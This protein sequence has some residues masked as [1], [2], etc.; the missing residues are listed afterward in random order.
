MVLELRDIVKTFP[1]VCALDGARFDLRPGEVHALI[2]ENG[3]GKSTLMNIIAGVLRP[4]AGQILLDGRPVAFRNPHHASQHGIA[5][6]FQE[7]SLVP[8]MCIAENM[9][10][11]RQPVGALNLIKWND[12]Y[13]RAAQYLRLFDMTVNPATPVRHLSVAQR[14][15]VEILKALS[16]EPRVVIL[17]EPTSSLT[18]IE[19]NLLFDNIR[20][21]KAQ[22]VAFIYISHHLSEIFQIADRVTVMR[23]GKYVQT[24]NV[25]EA[26]EDLL[27]RRMVGREL[28]NVY[29][30]RAAPVGD[31]YFRIEQASR[32]PD[33][34]DIS[35]HL[36]RGEILGLAGLVGA[37]R[38]Q[39][40]RALA[41]LE[42]LRHGQIL[43]D[44]SPL[45]IRSPQ[46]AIR[47]GIGYLTEDR[48]DQGLFLRMPIRDNCI[49]PSLAR[50]ANA[51]GAVDESRVDR[52]AESSRARFNIITPSTRQ[53]VGHL[54]GGN[55]QKVLL[56]MW[57]GIQPKV[58]IIDEPTRGVDV[59][60]RSDIYALLRDLAATGVGILM[61]S[62][63]LQEILGL[64][65]RILVM[66]SGRLAAEFSR[67]H[68]TE[69]LIIAAA[70]GARL[71]SH[72]Q[73]TH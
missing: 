40:A 61:V 11:H 64:S 10:A 58:L 71:E 52:F 37:G 3:A 29:G 16:Q 41:G 32:S 68:A 7:L 27:I 63:D 55:Q 51:L 47:H 26:T 24:L 67:E 18:A 1:G 46:Q 59:G 19:T 2:G 72:V 30:Q 33:F 73:L 5:V 17:D 60:A 43:L 66:R 34:H 54:S 39:L 49:A 57:M 48:K 28:K 6:V 22:G 53:P 9:F 45:R 42:P 15:V 20:R 21:L 70:T 4:D 65:D 69:E 44:N 8:N 12:L 35:F 62:S 31:P 14:Q 23:D 50:F 36:R 13:A 38:T 25:A 56:S